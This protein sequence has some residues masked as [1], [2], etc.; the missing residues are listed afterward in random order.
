MNI[1]LRPSGG[2]GEYEL[3]GRQG[4]LH[5][6]DL[7]GLAIWLEILPGVAINAFSHCVLKDGKPRIRLTEKGRNAHPSSLVAAAMMLPKPRRERHETKGTNLLLWEQFVVQTIRVNIAKR[8]NGVLI[9]PVDVRLENGDNARL[10]INFAQRMARVVKVWAA[11]A[12]GNDPVT[13]AVREHAA[14]FTSAVSTQTALVSSYSALHDALGKPKGDLLP[15]VEKHFGILAVSAATSIEPADAESAEAP[16]S[17]DLY[18]SPVEA[19]IERAKQWRLAVVRG[20]SAANFRRSVQAAYDSRCLF[21]GQRLPRLDVTSSAGVDAAHILPWSR[22]NLD[23]VGNGLCLN[24]QCHWAFDEG[25]LRL[26]YDESANS[27]VVSIADVVAKS[28]PK[29]GFDLAHFETLC[30]LVPRKNLPKNTSEWPSKLYLTELNRFLDS[31][32]A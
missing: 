16:L 12:V 11:A 31:E 30:G 14:A 20:T 3:A 10:D 17:E 13:I 29:S 25:V 8:A 9:S 23:S 19:R 7:F 5:V 21:T 18:L 28:A 27:Y 22:Y 1:S 6:H 4:D 24:K 26:Q 32:A 2:R 15:A